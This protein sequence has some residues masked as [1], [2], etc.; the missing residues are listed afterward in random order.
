MNKKPV[1]TE[2]IDEVLDVA[3]GLCF[4]LGAALTRLLI[5]ASEPVLEMNIRIAVFHLSHYRETFKNLQVSS[6]LVDEARP[7]LLKKLEKLC[8]SEKIPEIR[9]AL[10]TITQ[11]V[12]AEEDHVDQSQF[13]LLRDREWE[14][15]IAGLNT[16]ADSIADN[17][18]KDIQ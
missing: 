18:P 4:E 9:R 16:Y 1:F 14:I 11:A 13:P 3:S 17:K 2:E 8:D 10:E 7:A 6:V 5:R 15:T 12:L